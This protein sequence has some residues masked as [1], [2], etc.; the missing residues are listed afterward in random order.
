MSAGAIKAKRNTYFDFVKGL[1]CVGVVFLHVKLPNFYIDGVIQSWIRFSIPI[2]FMIS[3]YYAYYADNSKVSQRLPGKIKHVAKIGAVGVI[4]YIFFYIFMAL[5][6]RNHGGI[7]H[8]G[9]IFREKITVRSLIEFVLFNNDPLVNILWFVFALLY[10]YILLYFINKFNLYSFSYK[11]I[12]VL[13]IVHFILGNI[14]TICGMEISNVYYRNYLFFGMPFFLLG[15]YIHRNEE[16]LIERTS[17]IKWNY[18]ILIGML[19][20]SV[21][22]YFTGRRELFIGAIVM[23]IAFMLKGC[24]YPEKAGS[25]FL[26]IIGNKYSLFIYIVHL[27]VDRIMDRVVSMIPGWNPTAALIYSWIKILLVFGASVFGAFVFYKILGMIQ[28]IIK[29]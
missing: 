21:E 16:L 6:G 29:K 26:T 12:P 25:N 4:Y 20:C 1:A 14:L 7:E 2:F 23:A 19:M 24:T 9:S 15:N 8:I 10:C 13:L 27:S 17:R 5:F 28:N 18:V 22:W 3:G 11:M